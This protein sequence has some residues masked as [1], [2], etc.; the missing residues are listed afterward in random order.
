MDVGHPG[1]HMMLELLKITYWWLELKEDIKKYVQ[2]CFK[3]Q[4]NKVQHQRKA[5]ELYP[6]DIPQGP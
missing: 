4:Q 1:Q 3:Y 6:L 2:E 5:G